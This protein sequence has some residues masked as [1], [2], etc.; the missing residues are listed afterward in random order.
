MR[1]VPAEEL[2]E[3]VHQQAQDLAGIGAGPLLLLPK[4][5]ALLQNGPNVP[6]PRGDVAAKLE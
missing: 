5:E 4:P 3:L 1:I 6:E 2:L